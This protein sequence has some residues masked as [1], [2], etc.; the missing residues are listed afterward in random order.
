MVSLFSHFPKNGGQPQSDLDKMFLA[1][2]SIN[3][4]SFITVT[5]SFLKL[6][7]LIRKFSHKIQLASI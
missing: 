4:E 1:H 3:P 6:G 2:G 5:A 7:R